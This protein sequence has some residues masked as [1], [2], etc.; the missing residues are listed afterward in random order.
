MKTWKIILISIL[1][2][3]LM[4]ACF[5]DT[6]EDLYEFYYEANQCDTTQITYLEH[7]EPIIRGKCATTGCHVA[8]GTGNGIFESYEGVKDKVNDG[9]L[10]RR[11]VV[12]Q[13]MPP[14][15]P[16]SDCQMKQIQ[17]WIALGAPEN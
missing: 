4:S 5:F 17:A 2:A 10:L 11:T 6:E 12:N 15:G 7:I 8:G 14:S 9:S 1:S 13:D 3:A 16:L